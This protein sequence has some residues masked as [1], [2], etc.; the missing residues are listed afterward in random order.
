MIIYK[1]NGKETNITLQGTN[2]KIDWWRYNN[3]LEE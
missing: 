1:H 2:N 3:L